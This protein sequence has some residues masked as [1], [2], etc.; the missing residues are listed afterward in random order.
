MGKMFAGLQFLEIKASSSFDVRS[1]P[2][3]N[4]IL[5]QKFIMLL[6]RRSKT[7]SS[8]DSFLGQIQINFN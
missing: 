3:R 2:D 1:L 4:L 8:A 7:E 6:G 5:T